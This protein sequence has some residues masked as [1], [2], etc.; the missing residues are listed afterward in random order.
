MMIVWLL[1]VSVAFMESPPKIAVTPTNVHCWAE[2]MDDGQ[3]TP[4]WAAAG[5]VASDAAAMHTVRAR[6]PRSGL[7][8]GFMNA[9]ECKRMGR[10][11]ELDKRSAGPPRASDSPAAAIRT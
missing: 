10:T 1:V 8:R 5:C 11:M 2:L 9:S 7:Q 4:G 3:A 6:A